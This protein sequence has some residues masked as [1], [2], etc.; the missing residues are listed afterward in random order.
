[1]MVIYFCS[2][3]EVEKQ[4]TNIT[5]SLTS[6]HKLMSDVRS[7]L[8]SLAKVCTLFV[9]PI[10]EARIAFLSSNILTISNCKRVTSSPLARRARVWC[11]GDAGKRASLRQQ[12]QALLWASDVTAQ[13][14][15]ERAGDAEYVRRDSDLDRH[16]T[17]ADQRVSDITLTFAHYRPYMHLQLVK[18]LLIHMHMFYVC[19]CCRIYNDLVA[20]APSLTSDTKQRSDRDTSSPLSLGTRKRR[21]AHA[22]TYTYQLCI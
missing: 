10:F 16:A 11:R 8:K 13:A 22:R 20:F 7:I 15:D 9:L 6:H 5:A 17:G 18:A 14:G 21:I 19:L 2:Q 4:V 12:L 1:M 3:E